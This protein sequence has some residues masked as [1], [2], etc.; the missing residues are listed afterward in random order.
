MKA[1]KLAR[2]LFVLSVSMLLFACG[3]V[4]EHFELFPL[5]WLKTSALALRDVLHVTGARLPWYYTPADTG[6]AVRVRLAD[7]MAP[8]LTL[9]AG[10][11]PHNTDRIM[12]VDA[13]GKVI[14][15]WQPDWFTIWPNPKHVPEGSRPKSRATLVDMQGAMLMPNGDVVFSFSELGLVR[16]N[17]CGTVEWK[18]PYRTHHSVAVD[19]RGNIWTPAEHIR[20]TPMADLANYDPPIYDYTLLE[21]SPDG[22]V[23]QEIHVFDLLRKNDL[24]GLLYL[25]STVNRVTTVSGDLLHLNAIQIFPDTLAQGVF[26]PGDVMISLRNINAI[27]VFDPKDWRLKFASIGRVLRQHD[28]HFVDGNT[29]SVFDNN[30]MRRPEDWDKPAA[31]ADS[32]YASRIVTISAVTGVVRV[33]YSG[34]QRHHFF[35]DIMGQQQALSNGDLLLTESTA[36]RIL[37]VDPNGQTVWEYVNLVGD[38]LKG[39]VSDGHRLPPRFDERFFAAQAARCTTPP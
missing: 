14:Q 24:M 34:S 13:S 12:V 25:S 28:P 31:A 18:V 15:Q 26:A 5:P 27:L 3:V 4:A 16:M 33:L 17:I 29:I 37:E 2:L 23:L 35:T 22:K 11:G 19:D 10:A 21:I 7:R 39:L 8:G 32:A 9:V 36:G 6:P 1:D 20:H 38:G 30:N